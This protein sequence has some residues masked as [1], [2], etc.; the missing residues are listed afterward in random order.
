MTVPR[1]EHRILAPVHEQLIDLNITNFSS[2][3]SKIC[4]WIINNHKDIDGFKKM[5]Y[6]PFFPKS[7][8]YQ[9][10]IIRNLL[11]SANSGECWGDIV[12][13]EEKF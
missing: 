7:S 1:L 3:T 13:Q 6:I 8:D 9:N 2:K 11:I 12:E 10:Y 4:D 5:P